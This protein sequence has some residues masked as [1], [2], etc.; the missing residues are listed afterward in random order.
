MC[1]C[2]AK[3]IPFAILPLL[4]FT[5]SRALMG[6]FVNTVWMK[7]VGWGFAVL[8][9]GINFYLVIVTL[10][11]AGV[12]GGA[13]VGFTIAAAVYVCM[14]ALLV[15]DEARAIVQWVRDTV[16]LI[17]NRRRAPAGSTIVAASETES[18]RMEAEQPSTQTAA[19]AEAD[20][21]AERQ[22]HTQ[23][24]K[25]SQP[26]D[27]AHCKVIPDMVELSTHAWKQ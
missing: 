23:D 10:Q 15:K 21:E 16:A 22:V 18:S 11:A 20:K 6:S 8:V 5:S 1:L 14:V 7:C 27:D 3:L 4:H 24:E 9:M 13:W 26:D 25:V 19:Q 2:H 12:N 17:R